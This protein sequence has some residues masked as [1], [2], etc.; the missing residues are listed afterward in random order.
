MASLEGPSGLGSSIEMYLSILS[1][2]G[3]PRV[4]GCPGFVPNS[5]RTLPLL[6]GYTGISRDNPG[7]KINSRSEGRLKKPTA[8]AAGIEEIKRNMAD[9][10][11]NMKKRKEEC[12]IGS[13]SN[14]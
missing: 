12:F 3:V 7:V 11:K 4:S 8:C 10:I 6:A 9:M 5:K 14:F 1:S 2:S 13:L